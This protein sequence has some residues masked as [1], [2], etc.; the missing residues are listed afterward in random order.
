MNTDT[1]IDCY[2]EG[3]I[4]FNQYL[5]LMRG[6]EPRIEIDGDKA[7]FHNIKVTGAPTLK[8]VWESLNSDI[9][10][11]DLQDGKISFLGRDYWPEYLE[12]NRY[13]TVPAYHLLHEHLSSLWHFRK[14]A[15]TIYKSR[16]EDV[17]YSSHRC[18]KW[19]YLVN[20]DYYEFADPINYEEAMEIIKQNIKDSQND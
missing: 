11:E 2:N 6:K 15:N 4:G 18:R 5:E 10:D 1:I 7:I 19:H 20:K 12:D 13:I 3:K 16:G 17:W 14:K 9:T 8:D